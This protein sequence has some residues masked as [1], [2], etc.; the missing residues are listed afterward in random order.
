MFDC[1]WIWIFL[2]KEWY[3]NGKD[4]GRSRPRRRERKRKG[5]WTCLCTNLEIL[6]LQFGSSGLQLVQ[7]YNRSNSSKWIKHC[8][9]LPCCDRTTV[10]RGQ[11][12]V[13]VILDSVSTQTSTASAPSAESQ[14]Y[15]VEPSDVHV[16]IEKRTTMYQNLN[17]TQMFS[18]MKSFT[19]TTY[20][21]SCLK[22]DD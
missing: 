8:R 7:G 13:S 18:Q 1:V 22:A 15:R 3:T 2:K 6:T 17:Q 16:A 14:Q 12:E 19:N 10:D 4:G 11:P 20:P 9:L 21:E 5:N